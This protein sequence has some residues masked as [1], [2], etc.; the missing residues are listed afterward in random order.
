[1][2]A[3]RHLV[4]KEF[5]QVLR[6]RDMLRII[7]LVP[8]IQLFVFAYA[9]ST[10]LRNVPLG[11]L[12]QDRSATSRRLIEAF[13]RSDV[14]VEGPAVASPE[15]LERVLLREDAKV[16]L[17]IPAGFEESFERGEDAALGV[18]VDG[19]H[20]SLGGRAAG[21]ARS[22]VRR[23]VDRMRR[24]KGRLWGEPTAAPASSS[25]GRTEVLTRFF[26]NPE[27]VSRHHMV[28][29]I[30]V[31]LI[32]VI[33][34]LLTGMAVVREKELGTLE[35]L[36]VTPITP[37]QLVAGKTIPYAV[38]AFLE[39]TLATTV[40][41]FWFRLPLEGS[42]VLLAAAALAYLLVT[43]GIGLLA[44]TVSSTQQQAM[45]TVWF[46]LVSGILLSGFFFPVE[47]MPRWAQLISLAD[48]LRH[49]MSVVRGIFLKGAGIT[50]LWRELT[51]LA[52]M[53]LVVF[54][55]AVAR[56]EKRIA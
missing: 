18:A 33:S 27:L 14:Y 1:M 9:A 28:P 13:H 54:S 49:M 46:F 52:V 15:A 29:G 6:D 23:E 35:Q 42:V 30:V 21:Y 22:L 25:A 55:V 34:T 17:W 32:T 44:S 38:I 39:L 19:Q 24:E 3:I 10:D 11:V 26:Y 45:L 51:A 37:A 20:S 53:G 56:F 47:N 5:R 40:A 16:T 41:V 36:L 43:L 31:L 12:D 50:D 2:R 7:F 8:L 4:R 48:P